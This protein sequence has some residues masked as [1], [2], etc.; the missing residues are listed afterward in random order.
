MQLLLV[1][2]AHN[3][4]RLQRTCNPASVVYSCLHGQNVTAMLCICAYRDSLVDIH[5][6][7][8]RKCYQVLC[9]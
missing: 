7:L 4:V 3:D 2:A 5:C 8:A 1:H 9:S 6:I